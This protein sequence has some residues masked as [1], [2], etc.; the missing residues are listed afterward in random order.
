MVE[1][2]SRINEDDLCVDVLGVGLI[3]MP[4]LAFTRTFTPSRSPD[5]ASPLWELLLS[6]RLLRPGPPGAVLGLG[7]AA[8]GCRN[9][10]TRK[11]RGLAD[12]Q[13][14]LWTGAIQ[15]VAVHSIRCLSCNMQV[16]SHRGRDVSRH[17]LLI[18]GSFVLPCRCWVD[19]N[20]ELIDPCD[21]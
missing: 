3:P 20:F 1:E 9:L 11:W 8:G 21:H 19:S 13:R 5:A 2:R 12:R 15:D 4:D 14:R 10:Q 18:V 17:P 7:A 16:S 6:H